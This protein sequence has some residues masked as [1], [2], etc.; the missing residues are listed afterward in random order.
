MPYTRAS[1][2]PQAPGGIPPQ[3]APL[4]VSTSSAPETAARTSAAATDAARPPGLRRAPERVGLELAAAAVRR[5]RRADAARR[6]RATRRTR[7]TTRSTRSSGAASCGTARCP[8]FDA[9]RAPTQHPLWVLV[10][11][12]AR[13]ARAGRRPRPGAADARELPGARVG[14]LPARQ[15]HSFTM[16]VGLDGGGDPLHALRLP[17]PRGARLPRHPVPGARRLGR[18]AR[19]RAPAPRHA[20]CWSCSCCAGLL[21]PEAWLLSGLYWLWLFPARDVAGADHDRAARRRPRR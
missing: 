8:S 5:P 19:G 2:M 11:D 7:T 20:R 6:A 10:R 3:P 14:A 21:R 18:R 12:G 9:Y 1:S 4:T 16:L 13:A 17:V 15:A